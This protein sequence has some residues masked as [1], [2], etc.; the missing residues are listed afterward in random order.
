M[1]RVRGDVAHAKSIFKERNIYF[2]Q[3]CYFKAWISILKIDQAQAGPDLGLK[4]S[5]K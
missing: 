2:Y 1:K 5:L 3:T 4:N